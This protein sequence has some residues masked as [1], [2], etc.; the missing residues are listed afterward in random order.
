MEGG[1]DLLSTLENHL[2]HT[3]FTRHGL[4]NYL[5]RGKKWILFP[6]PIRPMVS[7]HIY[8]TFLIKLYLNYFKFV[9]YS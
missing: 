1:D 4:L 6:Y 7:F 2:C 3:Y 9:V 8:L 5:I